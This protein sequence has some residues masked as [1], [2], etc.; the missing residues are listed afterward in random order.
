MSASVK[1]PVGAPR[2]A[3]IE[4][5]GKFLVAEPFFAPAPRMAVSRDGRAGVGDLVLVTPSSGR[6]RAGRGGGRAVI[7]R[8]LGRP[9][10]ARDV[11]E[12]FMLDRGLRRSFDPAVEHEARESD[13]GGFERLDEA[14]RRD[15][16]V[17]ADVHDRSCERA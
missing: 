2:V 15:L 10:V 16:R 6:T 17:A 4:R 13:A 7:S 14:G 8:R 12:A 11:I 3:V 5:R 1:A 9:D